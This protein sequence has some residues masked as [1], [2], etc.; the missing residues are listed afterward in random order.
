MDHQQHE[1]GLSDDKYPQKDMFICDVQDAALKEIMPGMEHPFY[2]LSKKPDTKIVRYDHGENWLE[3]TPSVKGRATIYDKDILIFATSQIMAKVNEG[4]EPVSR[5]RI[6]CHELLK[7]CNR[8]T[9]GK[10]YE[11]LVAAL[12]RLAGTRI[13]TNI[14]SGDTETYTNFGLIDEGSVKRTRGLD[15]RI[16]W[17]E[18]KVSD[19][20]FDAIKNKAVL[21]LN[22]AYFRLRQPTARRI[23]E[24]ARKHCG[25]KNSFIISLSILQKKAGSVA[26]ERDFKRTLLAIMKSQILPDFIIEFDEVREMV[27]FI[28]RS[29]WWVEDKLDIKKHPLL[30][31]A[32]T[33]SQARKI[34]PEGTRVQEWH[35][36]WMLFWIGNGCVNLHDPDSAFLGFC[37]RKSD[38]QQS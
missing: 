2:S 28:N 16:K 18:L 8:G 3:I 30:Q 22:P 32:S 24:I 11:R 21:T 5:I 4:L 35:K 25:R 34:V 36:E 19:W 26:P 20:V 27:K 15:G 31:N 38:E 14:T 17:V 9:A 37:K 12:D 13:S 7:F 23:Y 33:Y 1:D 10:D 6:N 29:D